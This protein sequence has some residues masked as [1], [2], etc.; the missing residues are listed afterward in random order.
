VGGNVPIRLLV[1]DDHRVL[2]EALEMV[3]ER[4]AELEMVAPSVHSPEEAIEICRRDRPDVVVMDISFEGSMT[5]I[6]ATRRILDVSAGTGVLIVTTHHDDALMVEAA[7]AGASGY[8]SK[9]E[10]VEAVLNAAKAVARGEV[11]FDGAALTKLMSQV[12]KER[13]ATRLAQA[14]LD[15]LTDREREIL[16]LL[17]TG[18]RNDEIA[19]R[20]FIS[21]FTVQSHVSNILGKLGLRSKTEAVAFALGHPS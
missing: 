9:T 17:T 18:L 21:P 16:D 2:T 20:L 4:D 12:S 10:G 7:E 13:E 19:K 14:R 15:R 1:C 8:L 3:L 5:G 6:E 11:L